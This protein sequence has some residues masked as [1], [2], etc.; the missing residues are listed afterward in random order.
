M[1]MFNHLLIW[2]NM[3][4]VDGSFGEGGGQILRTS[5]ALSALTGKAVRVRNI[6][7]GRSSPGLRPQHLKAVEAAALLCNAETSGLEVGSTEVSFTPGE[8][9]PGRLEVDVGTAGSVTLVLQALLPV[10]FNAPA[11]VVLEVVGGTDVKWSPTADYFQHVLCFLLR[12]IGCG[13]EVDVVGRG[14]YPQGGGKISVTV[15]PWVG[16]SRFEL[17]ERGGLKGIEV[18]SVATEH[19]RKAEVAERQVK[20]F[21]REITPHYEVGGIGRVYVDSLSAGSSFH[22]YAEFENTR[23]G[24]C[25]LG[26]RG[27][28]AEEVGRV[29]AQQLAAELNSGAPLDRHMADQIIPYLALA[30]GAVRVSE[31]TEH[32][33][34]SIHVANKFGFNLGAKG[35]V[36]F[37]E[38][39]H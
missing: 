31:L 16:R 33:R 34:T 23:M 18:Q 4:E 14:F 37:N 27:L 6:R 10:A 20:G 30:G 17:K 12:R 9:K 7:A 26:E 32:A 21:L 8:I 22:A 2:I 15:E 19:L 29:A 38:S 11:P 1:N 5:I 25:V 28:R 39:S 36:I 3:I 13:I 35:N 24:V